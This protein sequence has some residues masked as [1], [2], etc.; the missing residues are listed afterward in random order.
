MVRPTKKNDELKLKLADLTGDEYPHIYDT[1]VSKQTFDAVQDIL[2]GHSTKRQR[3]DGVD[4]TYRALM[5]CSECGCTITPGPKVKVQKNGN[6][7]HYLYYHCTDGKKM[8]TS[9]VHSISEPKLDAIMQDLLKQLKPPEE[10]LESLKRTLKAKNKEK[11]AFYSE[12][13][14]S[15]TASLQRIRQ[16]QE[17]AFDKLMDED[18]AQE[19]YDRNNERYAE[20]VKEIEEKQRQLDE[21]DQSYYVTVSYLLALCEHASDIFAVAKAKE[22]R[23]ILGLLLS[24]L[25]FDGE[26]AHCTL[27]EPFRGL[28]NCVNRSTWL[29]MRDSNPRMSG[30]EPDALPLG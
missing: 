25:E 28:F 27:K 13:R 23:Q 6:V 12:R 15:L 17:M 30:P 19:Q 3:Y 4:A 1:L 10:R 2:N 11:N 21:I 5:T 26:N 29:G 14:V 24:N 8:H 16:R 18:I 22:K 7:C 9:P 20:E